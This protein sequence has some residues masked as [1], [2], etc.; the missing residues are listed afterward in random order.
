MP[1]ARTKTR[2][3]V[4]RGARAEARKS[5]RYRALCLLALGRTAEVDRSLEELVG[6]DPMFKMSESDVSPRLIT[7]FHTVRRRLLPETVKRLYVD[8]KKSFE[9]GEYDSASAQ[10]KDLLSLLSDEDLARVAATVADIKILAEG[11]LKLADAEVKAAAVAAAATAAAAAAPPPA[12][13]S[14]VPSRPEPS[15]FFP[16]TTRT[17]SHRLR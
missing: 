3:R 2:S 11:F 5:K 9:D 17:S 1:R 4:C 12:P 15:A 10:F 14:S 6:R 16:S 8:A 13:P 7:I